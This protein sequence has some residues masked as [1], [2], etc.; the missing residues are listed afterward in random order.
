[1][2][3]LKNRVEIFPSSLVAKW[4][5]ISYENTPFFE[6]AEAERASINSKDY[7]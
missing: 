6:A 3:E 5:H 1:V 4:L 2:N 7:F